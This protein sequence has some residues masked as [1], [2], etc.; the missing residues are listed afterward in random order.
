MEAGEAAL[1]VQFSYPRIAFRIVE[2]D[3]EKKNEKE[4][5]PEQHS[6]ALISGIISFHGEY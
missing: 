2:N 1:I 3:L 5:S 4:A 6:G